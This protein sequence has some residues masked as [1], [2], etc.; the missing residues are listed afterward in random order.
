[1]RQHLE[2]A[3]SLGTPLLI[4]DILEELD[5]V[6]D[7]VLDKNF[8]KV[9]NAL[10]VKLGDREIDYLSDFRLY[11]TTKLPNPTYSPEISARTA[12]IDFT[13]TMKGKT[14]TIQGS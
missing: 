3:L 9:G 5:P 6:L 12:V 2:D 13:V 11:F 10:K 8:V 7:N 14:F 1:M 4:E